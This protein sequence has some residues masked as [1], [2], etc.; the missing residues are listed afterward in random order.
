M[1][2][3]AIVADKSR[4]LSL[5]RDAS[6]RQGFAASGAP[7]VALGSLTG[8]VPRPPSNT[9][10]ADAPDRALP[11]PE[12]CLWAA[13]RSWGAPSEKTRPSDGYGSGIQPGSTSAASC[14]RPD[15]IAIIV[16]V[17]AGTRAPLGYE[18]VPVTPT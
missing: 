8:P 4:L 15:L 1:W 18:M 10:A 14:G 12:R 2:A 17:F 7:A 13:L 9:R 16:T 6:L 3:T 11:I 5:S